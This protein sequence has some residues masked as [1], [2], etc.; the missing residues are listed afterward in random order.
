[1]KRRNKFMM[2]IN[3]IIYYAETHC[4]MG[5]IG[6]KQLNGNDV[7]IFRAEEKSKVKD[8][9]QYFSPDKAKKLYD[10]HNEDELYG[11]IL[12]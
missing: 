11:I 9:I 2:S 10:S 12:E 3:D 8:F 6:R 4:L 7:M 5:Y 1:M